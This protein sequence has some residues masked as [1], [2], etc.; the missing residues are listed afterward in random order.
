MHKKH[1]HPAD[2]QSDEKT[3]GMGDDQGDGKMSD[4][5]IKKK[6]EEKSADGCEFC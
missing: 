1:D 4:E 3:F 5:D 2:D 6:D